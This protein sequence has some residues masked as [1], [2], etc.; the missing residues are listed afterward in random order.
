[1][2]IFVGKGIAQ[3]N[4]QVGELTGDNKC[5]NGHEDAQEEEYGADV[6]AR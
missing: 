4:G 6:H 2:N 5:L 1:M 3:Y